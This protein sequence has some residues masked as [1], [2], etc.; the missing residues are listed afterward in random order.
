MVAVTGVMPSAWRWGDHCGA[1][2]LRLLYCTVP[3][4]RFV[5]HGYH[6]RA[7]LLGPRSNPVSP[8]SS[9]LGQGPA[10]ACCH[11]TGLTILHFTWMEWVQPLV[12]VFSWRPLFPTL[13]APALV[14]LEAP[15][16]RRSSQAFLPLWA[17]GLWVGVPVLVLPHPAPRAWW[18]WGLAAV[19]LRQ[20]SCECGRGGHAVRAPSSAPGARGWACSPPC[21]LILPPG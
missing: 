15:L 12:C 7:L 1:K 10:L 19:E 8:N 6:V 9:P 2:I 17:V 14:G 13:C 18:A 4:S 21:Q 11:L 16:G 5:D 3:V 20:G